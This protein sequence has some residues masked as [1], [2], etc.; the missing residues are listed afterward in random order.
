ME[1]LLS[2]CTGQVRESLLIVVHFANHSH[3]IEWPC[4][5]LTRASATLWL[6][7]QCYQMEM[8]S[9]HFYSQNR[10]SSMKC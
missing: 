5:A 10:I 7:K 9:D 1:D 8:V 2:D 6:S 3:P 4:M